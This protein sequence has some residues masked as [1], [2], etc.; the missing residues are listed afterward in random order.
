M[1]FHLLYVHLFRPFLKYNSSNTPLPSH[2]SPRKVC[3]QAAGSISKLMRLYKRTYGLRQICNIAVYIVHSACTIHLLNL[4][5]KTAK[6]D[7]THGVKHLEEIAE[8]W[9]CARRTLSILSVLARK[10]KAELPEEAATVL[11]RTDARFGYFSTAD[12]PSPK[13]EHVVATPP[14]TATSPASHQ[15]PNRGPGPIRPHT[16]LQ[17]SLYSYPPNTQPNMS[18]THMTAT[19]ASSPQTQTHNRVPSANVVGSMSM[20]NDYIMSSIPYP[21][22]ANS[23]ASIKTNMTP[24]N[25]LPR[26]NS[27]SEAS[28]GLTRQ[29]SPNTMFGGVEALVESQDWWL[30]DQANLYGNWM[31]VGNGPQDNGGSTNTVGLPGRTDASTDLDNMAGIGAGFYMPPRNGHAGGDGFVD[32]DDWKYD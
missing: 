1:F 18:L 6:R 9:L 4:P 25:D 21:R 11:T 15:P 30:R 20:P 3:S 7:I 2:V 24:N 22:Y 31:N 14:S 32:D 13:Q 17:R 8:D 26:N 10:W 29:V 12:V 28:G 27:A 19:T 16:Q 23:T 5:E